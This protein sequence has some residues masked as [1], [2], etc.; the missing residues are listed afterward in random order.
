MGEAQAIESADEN[1]VI[2]RIKSL[3]QVDVNGCTVLLFINGGYSD[4]SSTEGILLLLP[5]LQPLSLLVTLDT[6]PQVAGIFGR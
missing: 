6:P 3:G 4:T 2:N 1:T 5:R